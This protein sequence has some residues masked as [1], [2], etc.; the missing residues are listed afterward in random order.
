MYLVL[1]ILFLALGALMI[2]KPQL[3]Y[4]LIESWKSNS[5]G[6]PS[7]TYLFSTRFGGV[8]FALV[9]IVAVVFQFIQ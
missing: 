9:G 3:I 8:M 5:P 2:F 6:E 4:T 7:K 1:G